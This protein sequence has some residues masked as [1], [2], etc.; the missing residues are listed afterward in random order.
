MRKFA[1]EF[2]DHR[3]NMTALA[4]K[5]H[6]YFAGGEA[7]IDDDEFPNRGVKEQQNILFRLHC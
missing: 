7:L 6:L 3:T 4:S 1:N 2:L 5:N